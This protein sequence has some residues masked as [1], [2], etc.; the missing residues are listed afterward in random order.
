MNQII[1]KT[2]EQVNIKLNESRVRLSIKILNIMSISQ[3]LLV[4]FFFSSAHASLLGTGQ[5]SC[6]NAAGSQIAC[7]ATGQDAA[8]MSGMQWSDSRFS[9]GAGYIT[10]TMTALAWPQDANVI[11]NGFPLFDADG[12][13]GDGKVTWEHALVIVKELNAASYLGY[14]DWRLPNINEL[15]SLQDYK[16][17]NTAAWLNQ[18]GFNSFMSDRY[19]SSTTDSMNT[20]VAKGINFALGNVFTDSANGEKQIRHNFVIP[21]RG[22]PVSDYILPTNQLTCYGTG[23]NNGVPSSCADSGQDGEY[24]IG[25]DSNIARFQVDNNAVIDQNTKLMWPRNLDVLATA[26]S[27]SP[28]SLLSWQESLDYMNCLNISGFLGYHDWK[29]PNVNE[30]G[31]LLDHGN[32]YSAAYFQSLGFTSFNNNYVWAST[33]L[34]PSPHAAWLVSLDGNISATYKTGSYSV[35]P[36]RNHSQNESMLP[37]LSP[38]TAVVTSPVTSSVLRGR[39]IVISG[40]ASD[41]GSGVANVQIS[42]DAGTTWT[43]ATGTVEWNCVWLLPKDGTYTITVKVT[44]KAGNIAGQAASTVVVV[45]HL[46]FSY[47][48]TQFPIIWKGQSIS[49]TSSIET[50][51]F[52]HPLFGKERKKVN[53]VPPTTSGSSITFSLAGEYYLKINGDC[54]LKVLVLDPAEPISAGVIRIFDF[55]VANM[56]FAQ[57]DDARFY[58]G[59]VEFVN[60]WFESEAPARLLCGT[61][62]VVFSLLLKDRFS[63]PIRKVTFPGAFKWEGT[64]YFSSHNLTE[65]Y[66]PDKVKWV[67]F[68]INYA[69]FVRWMSALEL[70]RY[71]REHSSSFETGYF[72]YVPFS[73]LDIYHDAPRSFLARDQT[74]MT[75]KFFS[76]DQVSKIPV[77]Y[78]WKETFRFFYSGVAYWGNN[79]PVGV[80]GTEFFSGDYV[81]ANMHTDAGLAKAAVDWVKSYGLQVTEVSPDELSQALANGAQAE[82]DTKAWK[83]RIP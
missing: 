4:L 24:R 37:D 12:I 53:P 40:T 25:Y 30:L 15:R 1:K 61:T 47:P 6:F 14:N 39:Q 52:F 71:L 78:L 21:V 31:S 67:L 59:N 22:T 34:M 50:I 55:C 42:T 28:K 80:S 60:N 13:S 49:A 81:F 8:F 77:S 70:V 29:L 26:N 41:T 62:Q 3:I 46:K 36:V 56:L 74:D 20:A 7:A 32:V 75:L 48:D 51:E 17:A 72:D 38:P 63:L 68:D 83:N 27:C 69:F 5:T 73:Q 23:V 66:L 19:W 43:T 10:D 82:I 65:V 11:K 76:S 35:I 79:M 58:A 33:T 57:Q 44:D 18:T 9:V 2:A 64:T 54:Y 45:D 16:Q